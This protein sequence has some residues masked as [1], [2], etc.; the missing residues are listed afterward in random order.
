MSKKLI[1][2]VVVAALAA[3]VFIM[4]PKGGQPSDEKADL[5]IIIPRG[6]SSPP[7]DWTSGLVIDRMYF[8]PPMIRVVVGVNSTIQWVN[9][10]EVAHSATSL[11]TPPNAQGFDSGL[12]APG[13]TFTT[14]I[15]KPGTY[16]YYCT[17][18]PWAGGVIQAS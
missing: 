14:R 17:L 10:D 2:L 9:R 3:A 7:S 1:I 8:D 18:H 5:I 13:G 16:V 12:I 11:E 4:I 15:S 6:A